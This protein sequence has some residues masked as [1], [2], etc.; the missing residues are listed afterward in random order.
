MWSDLRGL[1][2]TKN[3]QALYWD[4]RKMALRACS[5][6][7]KQQNENVNGYKNNKKKM[8]GQFFCKEK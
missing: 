2:K 5:K 1:V 8:I 3:A 7:K 6:G 4:P